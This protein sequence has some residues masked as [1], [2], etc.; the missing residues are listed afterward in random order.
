MKFTDQMLTNFAQPLSTTEEQQCKN[1]IRMV[2]DALK[3][4]GFQE[5]RSTVEPMYSETNAYF[6]ELS[7]SN[8]KIKVFLQ[9]SYANN[10]N[11]RT[12]SDVDI[13]VVQEEI[14]ATRYRPGVTNANY[15][16]E[17]AN[18]SSLAFKDE[19]ELALRKRFGSDVNREN[20][21]IKINGNSHRKDADAVPSRRHK[22]FSADWWN[23]PTNYISGILITADSG[24]EIINY[25]EQHIK[26]GKNK[27]LETNFH[28]KKMVRILKKMRY[29][30]KDSNIV[31]AKSVSSFA[32][33][34]LLWNVPNSYY[35]KQSSNRK[36][37]FFKQLINYLTS[38]LYLL[39]NFKEANGIK[40]LFADQQSLQNMI[41]FIT[42]LESFYEYD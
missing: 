15:H 1:A 24:E 16:F 36:V 11:V 9:G 30:M 7:S 19:V 17:N 4:L 38:Y 32:L 28:Y 33:E 31:A 25:P 35:L 2:I 6:Q 13:A 20:K 37:L 39:S 26:N 3:N 41:S 23:D 42:E 5:L 10:T 8:R 21:S 40:P 27:N 14:F 29:L 34:S 18:S 12:Q 22:D